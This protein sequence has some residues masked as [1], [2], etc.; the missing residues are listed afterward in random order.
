MRTD[1]TEAWKRAF[2]AETVNA[3]WILTLTVDPSHVYKFTSHQNYFVDY[4]PGLEV[5]NPVAAE[6]DAKTNKVSMSSFTFDITDDGELR[7]I[8]AERRI[9]RKTSSFTL[10]L[11]TPSISEGD[12][13]AILS[14]RVEDIIPLEG[15]PMRVVAYD[16]RI[17][18]REAK[19]ALEDFAAK[20]PVDVL[21]K[22]LLLS[23]AVEGTDFDGSTM[24]PTTAQFVATRSAHFCIAAVGEHTDLFLLNRALRE[25]EDA[26]PLIDDLCALAGGALFPSEAGPIVFRVFDPDATPVYAFTN[27]D[28]DTLEPE[29]SFKTIVNE[30]IVGWGKQDP[31]I[32]TAH[33][34]W[35]PFTV[36]GFDSPGLESLTIYDETSQSLHGTQQASLTPRFMPSKALLGAA[37]DATATAITV[38]GAVIGGFAGNR[39]EIDTLALVQW[40]NIFGI[41][42]ATFPT[43]PGVCLVSSGQPAFFQIDKEIVRVVGETQSSISTQVEV[44]VS[45]DAFGDGLKVARVSLGDTVYTIERGALGTTAVAHVIGAPMLDVTIPVRMG[46]LVLR[47]W[48]YGA[49]RIKITTGAHHLAPELG[50]L[51]TVTRTEVYCGYGYERGIDANTV[52]RVVRKE[53]D[54]TGDSPSITWV[55]HRVRNLTETFTTPRKYKVRQ[56]KVTADTTKVAAGYNEDHGIL[57]YVSGMTFDPGSGLTGTMAKGLGKSNGRRVEHTDDM[58]MPFAANQDAWI[59]LDLIS[60]RYRIRRAASPAATPTFYSWEIPLRKVTTG[61]ATISSHTDLRPLN[62]L[63]LTGAVPGS[64]AIPDHSIGWL[65][66]AIPYAVPAASYGFNMTGPGASTG[67]V[68]VYDLV[69]TAGV[70]ITDSSANTFAVAFADTTTVGSLFKRI[71]IGNGIG[72]LTPTDGL[73]CSTEPLTGGV[74]KASA[75]LPLSGGR[76]TGTAR[77]GAVQLLAAPA[78]GVSGSTINSTSAVLTARFDALG[79]RCVWVGNGEENAAPAVGSVRGT[80]AANNN[81]AGAD[82]RIGGGASRG[83]VGGGSVRLR[84]T[85]LGGAGGTLNTYSDV[86][87]VDATL[88]TTISGSLATPTAFFVGNGAHGTLGAN[89]VAIGTTALAAGADGLSF[90]RN[91]TAAGAQGIA[92]GLAASAPGS[93]TIAIG[94]G[95]ATGSNADQI[96]IGRGSSAASTNCVAIGSTATANAASCLAVGTGASARSSTNVALGASAAAGASTTATRA[97]AVGGS[98]TSNAVGAIA[99][100]GSSSATG[101]GSITIGDSSTN[102]QKS[103]VI[104]DHVA[105][106]ADGQLCIGM[107]SSPISAVYIGGDTGATRVVQS[108]TAVALS[109]QP[110]GAFSA[111][112]AGVNLTI[113]GGKSTGSAAGGSVLLAVSPAG[114]AG[115][116]LNALTTVLTVDSTLLTTI[117]GSLATPTAFF[118]GNGAHG[119]LG[120]NSSAIGS[121]ALAAGNESISYGHSATSAGANSVALGKSASSSAQYSIAIGDASVASV[122][123]AVAVGQSA[124]ASGQ[125]STAIGPLTTAS[126]NAAVALGNGAT[127]NGAQSIAIGNAVTVGNTSCVVVGDS[128]NGSGTFVVHIAP[129]G[130]GSANQ[131][132]A[133]GYAAFVHTG[134]SIAIGYN[135]DATGSSAIVLGANSVAN[136]GSA[137]VIGGSSTAG[138]A[139]TIVIGPS[140]SVSS[141]DAIAIGNTTGVSGLRGIAIGQNCIASAADTIAISGANASAQFALAMGY[142]TI[143]SGPASIALNGIAVQDRDIAIGGNSNAD[144]GYSIALGY[145][146][147]TSASEAVAI[148][149]TSYAYAGTSVAVGS[150]AGVGVGGDG[151]VSIGTQ[152]L[153]SYQNAITIGSTSTAD[154][155]YCVVLGAA[156]TVSGGGYGVAVGYGVLADGTSAIAI[157]W[158]SSTVAEYAIAIGY[159]VTVTHDYAI[160]L[161]AES[162]STRDH[163]LTIGAVT[164]PITQD[165]RPRAWATAL[166]RTSYLE[167]ETNDATVTTADTWTVPADSSIVVKAT[168]TARDSTGTDYA[169]FELRQTFVRVGAGAPVSAPLGLSLIYSDGTVAALATWIAGWNISGN[170]VELDVQGAVATQIFWVITY[171][172]QLVG[173]NT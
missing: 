77:G 90:G 172:L 126:A 103:I 94:N 147:G 135:T 104:G 27:D 15:G 71:A 13:A 125:Q 110:S 139:R 55:L 111:N 145:A 97:V 46:D 88:L 93:N 7:R 32:R 137:I 140:M 35:N 21:K 132:T 171:E 36:N 122:Q 161:G 8:V 38:N 89:A 42:N 115:S 70:L 99:V 157:G 117:A 19:I 16:A 96:A 23:G 164:R 81:S 9:G 167:V 29:E 100:G 6:L 39:A 121:V 127:A 50:D 91:A 62:T 30:A 169:T 82:I 44:G 45:V 1:L 72:A 65:Q 25:P 14:G 11:G 106:T 108:A 173:N 124:T 142:G 76:S 118:V 113:A 116:A 107:Q 24:N 73:I 3:I 4:A 12:F 10:K 153:A 158:A 41:N 64:Y 59:S 56:P 2:E 54:P 144:G 37:I 123:Y 43:T 162:G 84:V 80:Q 149:S 67:V 166:N 17:L 168:V 53:V 151:S 156:S 49:P 138:A 163:Q 79:E 109:I 75:N 95:A 150:Q 22:A 20:H 101:V 18:A 58:I 92:I 129:Q 34:G 85:P 87:V 28:I 114:G 83:N 40:P 165:M 133:L 60:G 66:I 154:T 26:Q 160:A 148:G 112:Q 48:A 61:A 155:P 141:A 152:A 143:A 170:D 131:T 63:S 68:N 128:A 5:T 74:D 52:W 102:A 120:T 86:L 146:A 78:G 57:K 33:A 31:S 98:A 136:G 130:G 159:S 105:S 51:V 134:G 69:N 119:V 47:Q